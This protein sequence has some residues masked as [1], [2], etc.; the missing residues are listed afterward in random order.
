MNGRELQKVFFQRSTLKTLGL[1]N[2]LINDYAIIMGE[3]RTLFYIP[4]L[5][6][7]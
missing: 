7:F 1:E 2:G 3:Q 5:K 6:T 4:I